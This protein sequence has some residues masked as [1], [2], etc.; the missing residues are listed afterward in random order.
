VQVCLTSEVRCEESPARTTIKTVVSRGRQLAKVEATGELLTII[1][2]SWIGRVR[3]SGKGWP[4]NA[5]LQS[6]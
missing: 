3:L 5:D 4:D 1:P 6:Y 2:K